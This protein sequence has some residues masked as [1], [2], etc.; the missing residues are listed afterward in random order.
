MS[1]LASSQSKNSVLSRS[2][3]AVAIR[4]TNVG[5]GDGE[6]SE[7]EK[8]TGDLTDENQSPSAQDGETN[9]RARSRT[10]LDPNYKEHAT[11]RAGQLSDVFLE[12]SGMSVY[13]NVLNTL[14]AVYRPLLTRKFLDEL[15]KAV[16]CILTGRDDCGL[17]AELTKS[18][19]SQIDKPLR[20]LV[21]SVNALRCQNLMP[22]SRS[23][24]AT[25]FLNLWLD[26]SMLARVGAVQDWLLSTVV[27]LPQYFSEYLGAAWNVI[28]DV[29][30]PP[31]VKYISDFMVKILKTPIDYVKIA[32]QV[33]IEIPVLNQSEQCQQGDL[34]QLIMWGM[35]HN[36][37][38]SFGN[39]LL[40]IFLAPEPAPCD[41]SSPECH[42]VQFAR[43]LDQDG[44]PPLLS[45]KRRP[46]SSLNSTSCPHVLRAG[47][48]DSPTTYALCLALSTLTPAELERVWANAC[49]T[50]SSVLAPLLDGSSCDGS[51]RQASRVSRSLNLKDLMCVYPNWTG[52]V[53]PDP[54]SVAFCAD[55]DRESFV[56]VVCSNVELIRLL[57][58]DPMN[59]W[60]PGYCANFSGDHMVVQQCKYEVWRIRMVD[61]SV[62]TFCWEQDRDRMENLLCNDVS[63]FMLV[64]SDPENAWL[65]PNCS[66]LEPPTEE[67]V[68]TQIDDICLYSAWLSPAFVSSDVV[69]ACIQHDERR[70]VR[71][72]CANSTFLDALLL[73]ELNGWV[74]EYCALSLSAPPTDPPSELS[75]WCN[76][77]QWPD[78]AVDPSVVG[79]CWQ[80]DQ[81]AFHR[82]VCCNIALFEKLTLDPQNEWLTAVCSDKEV[83]DRLP[84]VCRYGDWGRPVIVDMTDLAFCAELDARNFTRL[85]CYNETVLRNLLAN[86]DNTWLIQ[87]CVNRSGPG[88]SGGGSDGSGGLMG[89]RPEEQCQYKSWVLFIPGAS[90]LALCW[91]YDKANFI[92]NICLDPTL[93]AQLTQEPSSRWV[94]TLCN[95]Y[96]NVNDDSGYGDSGNSD[97]GNSDGGNGDGGNADGGNGDGGNGDG[98]NGDGENG[99]GGNGDGYDGNG[100]DG[101]ADGY[102][103]NGDGGNGNGG[104]GDGGNGDGGNAG[105][106]NADSH[107]NGSEPQPCQVRDLVRQL[108]W[109][110]GTDLS[111][112]CRPGAGRLVGLQ[113]LLRCGAEA[114]RP[115]VDSL[116]SDKMAAAV[117]QATNVA[118]VLLVALEES[119]MTSLRVSENIRLSVLES[120]MLYLEQETNFDNKRVL[121]QCFGKVLTSLMQTGRDGNSHGYFLIKEYFRIPLDS[122]RAVLSAVD[123]TTVRQIMQY[124]SRN[125]DTLQL[126]EEYR[127]NMVSVFFGTHLSRD[128]ALFPHLAPL[129]ALLSPADI[130][131][132]PNLQ[133]SPN[134]LSTIDLSLPQLSPAQRRAFGKWLGRSVG[135]QTVTA[136]G[137][138]LIRDTGNLIAYLP[139][140]DFQHL[141]PAQLLDGLD[142]LLKN[143]LSPIQGQFVAQTLVANYRNLT[144]DVFQS[145][146]NLTC[147]AQPQSLVAHRDPEVTTAIQDNI[148]MCVQQG[149][150]VSSDMISSLFLN[151]A[152]LQNPGSLSSERVAQLG[153][154]LPLLG[155][156][157][158][159]QLTPAQ[160]RPALPAL[161]T[162]PFTPNQLGQ[163]GQLLELGTLVSGVR[164]ETIWTLTSDTLLA[165]LPNMAQHTPGLSPPQANAVSTKLWGSEKVTEWLDEVEPLLPCTPLLS[166]Q[167]RAPLLLGNTSAVRSRVWNTQQA[168]ALFQEAVKTKPASLSIEDFMDLGT[169]ASG[170]DCATLRSIFQS[171]PDF[172]LRGVLSFLREQPAPLHTS[173]KKCVIEELYQFE[174]FSQLLGDLGLQIAL[175]ASVSTIQSFPADTLRDMIVREPVHFLQIPEIKKA[176][177]VDKMVQR[178]NMYT[179]GYS[180]EEFRSLGVMA[181]FVVDEVFLQVDRAFF[182]ETLDFLRGFCYSRSKRGIVAQILQEPGTFGPVEH[183]T[184]AI[185]DQV[186]RFIFFLPKK[187]VQKIPAELM[188]LERIERLFLSQQQWEAGEFGALCVQSREQDELVKLFAK[189]Q[190]VLQFFLGFLIIIAVYL[191]VAAHLLTPS[192]ENLHA[193]QPSAWSVTSLTYMSSGSF[194]SCLELIG[195]DPFLTSF[196]LDLLL[197]KVKKIYGPAS[198]FSP[199]VISRLGRVATRLSNAELAVLNLSQLSTIAALGSISSWSSTQLP[200][201][202]LSVLN[203]TRQ[204]PSQLDSSTMVA[205]GHIICGI[206][207]ADMKNLNAV[208]FSKA[209]L[210]LGGLRLSCSEEQL[211]VLVG[212]L[213]HSLAFGKTSS[214]GPQEFIEIGML[215]AGLP[216]MAMS[217]LVR[218]Q[219]EGISPLAISLIPADKFFVVFNQAQIRMFSYEQAVAVTPAQYSALTPLQRTALSMVLTPSEN[220]PVD[221]RGRS[222]GFALRPGPFS[223]LMEL[224]MLMLLFFRS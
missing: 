32:L 67:N 203:S 112:A 210:W 191:Y 102:G 51:P 64:L 90:L 167:L 209:A 19:S 55:N 178:L 137:P 207:T 1:G 76:Y 30:L 7:I 175:E 177:L 65:F 5:A 184:S 46:L 38:W 14:Y 217:S 189:K 142:V 86:L 82:N 88:G 63:F 117:N 129:L 113:L 198:A 13:Y 146:G 180:E 83:M 166:V 45:C 50:I 171:K 44:P 204:T 201:L 190:F 222:S 42:S 156:D 155:T 73:N 163:P 162:V 158:L 181:T 182:V 58:A 34:K 128:E 164:V 168:K 98:G 18:I 136:A 17:E 9:S 69:A 194:A 94:G 172:L 145:L 186:D 151:E 110:C 216:D 143:T 192:C 160:L 195:Q 134:V 206:N 25:N 74:G 54:A 208:E 43:S 10:V 153:D 176:L 103:G 114:L 135:A 150:R 47:P 121:L 84:E 149:M 131:S 35:I 169:L 57:V 223:L 188:T 122:L 33:G 28:S 215:A 200:V 111:A 187:A 220:K 144:A 152:E 221:F 116:L 24:Q 79:L 15:P 16:V 89:F 115:R 202:F 224:L 119:R 26:E 59:G 170:A 179:G 199:S 139:F 213:E 138:S 154:F 185:L 40:D 126:T 99:D 104:N 174:F 105:D 12:N 161:A 212:M 66:R 127:R 193:T 132:L 4:R 140:R 41:Y 214:W 20:S 29:T 109:T 93:L 68:L 125:Q 196:E 71:R 22:N 81:V 205:L 36:V 23:S 8:S 49:D 183:W 11:A 218:D 39:A 62:L 197:D 173:L 80:H 85:V 53:R 124:Y 123:I 52:V 31:V 141:S 97:G 91:D 148:R 100:Y 159:G 48:G 75:T 107:N 133:S 37:S 2:S 72:V 219:I 87:Y 130:L 118:V 61:A 77:H 106:G 3:R 56:R 165:A 101:N 60:L 92:S 27:Y 95:T 120:V 6:P 108:N 147:L 78:G 70:F 157:F 96:A 211:L 21:T